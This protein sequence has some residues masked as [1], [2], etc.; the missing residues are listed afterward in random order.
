LRQPDRACARASGGATR[1][2]AGFLARVLFTHPR[3]GCTIRL[4]A[5]GSLTL[6]SG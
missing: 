1:F 6:A 3:G 4:L 2:E 5:Y